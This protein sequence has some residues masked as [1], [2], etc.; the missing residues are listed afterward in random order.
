M[1]PDDGPPMTNADDPIFSSVDIQLSSVS[2][3]NADVAVGDPVEIQLVESAIHEATQIM[4]T[5]LHPMPF[6]SNLMFTLF[7]KEIMSK[8]QKARSLLLRVCVQL[9]IYPFSQVPIFLSRSALFSRDQVCIEGQFN[10]ISL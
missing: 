8:K 10:R 7:A 1:H 2:R 5:G 3:L 4:M 9:V 6:V